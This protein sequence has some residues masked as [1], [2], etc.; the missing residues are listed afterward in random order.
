[1]R[2]YYGSHTYYGGHTTYARLYD[3]DVFALW[4]LQQEARPGALRVPAHTSRMLC[5]CA[6]TETLGRAPAHAVCSCAG[7]ERLR[8]ISDARARVHSGLRGLPGP[9]GARGRAG[10]VRESL[11]MERLLKCEMLAELT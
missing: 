9:S 4:T 8:P 10:R 2:T 5:V 6:C 1:M 3:L 7:P 11:V